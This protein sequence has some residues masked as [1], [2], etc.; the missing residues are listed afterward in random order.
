M[1]G[2]IQIALKNLSRQSIEKFTLKSSFQNV[3]PGAA[4]S[5]LLENLIQVQIIVHNPRL[6]EKFWDE[7]QQAVF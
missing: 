4:T 5:V 6:S 7:E 3:V 2:W 1:F